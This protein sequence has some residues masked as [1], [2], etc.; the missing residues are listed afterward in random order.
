MK[1]P[2]EQILFRGYDRANLPIKEHI[3]QKLLNDFLDTEFKT[4]FSSLSRY[5]L[6][7]ISKEDFR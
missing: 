2:T 6:E 7:Q 1:T 4:R 3:Y 5:I